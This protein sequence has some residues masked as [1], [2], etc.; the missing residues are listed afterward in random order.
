M[1]A[2]AV[3]RHSQSATLAG[4]LNQLHAGLSARYPA[5]PRVAELAEALA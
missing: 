3:A 4:M 2:L 1:Q 5:D